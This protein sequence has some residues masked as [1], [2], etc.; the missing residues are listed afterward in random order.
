M[1][2]TER[3]ILTDRTIVTDRPSSAPDTPWFAKVILCEVSRMA[4]LSHFSLSAVSIDESRGRNPRYNP[5]HHL[6]G[7][8]MKVIPQVVLFGKALPSLY[9]P[10]GTAGADVRL[11]TGEING[12]PNMLGIEASSVIAA[13]SALRLRGLE[14]SVQVSN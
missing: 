14:N 1:G 11:L 9:R 3:A 5:Y 7:E 2:C 12:E 6:T 8:I 13:W 4:L 10:W